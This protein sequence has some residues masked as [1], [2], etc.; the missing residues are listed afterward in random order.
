MLES[1]ASRNN[2]LAPPAGFLPS[3]HLR[4]VGRE[5]T[6]YHDMVLTEEQ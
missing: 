4:A 6:M 1:L 5:K 3:V 2:N